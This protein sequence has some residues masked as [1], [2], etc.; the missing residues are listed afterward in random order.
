MTTPSKNIY[1]DEDVGKDDDSADGA[2][3]V[4][5]KTLL[6]AH[7]KNS[8]LQDQGLQYLTRKST[9][10]PVSEDGDPSARLEW[11]PA[12]KSALKKWPSSMNSTRKKAARRKIWRSV[13]R[14]IGKRRSPWKMRRKS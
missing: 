9:T 14:G 1:V 11:K 3:T 10:G 6:Y 7:I 13:R 5:Y 2:E 4:P 12:T 8:P